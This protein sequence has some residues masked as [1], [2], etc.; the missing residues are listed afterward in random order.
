MS[1]FPVAPAAREAA[2]RGLVDAEPRVFWTSHEGVS[3]EV[4]AADSPDGTWTVLDTKPGGVGQS[5]TFYIDPASPAAAER[6]YK[7]GVPY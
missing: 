1:G 6:H 4:S 3:Y 5:T 7:I 2:R